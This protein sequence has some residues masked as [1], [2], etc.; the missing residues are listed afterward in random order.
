MIPGVSG[1][2]P[3]W[4]RNWFVRHRHPVSR[5]LHYV[6]IPLTV[7]AV[8]LAGYQFWLW[9]WD[10]WWRPG[11]LLIAGYL[12]QWIGHRLE[13]NDMGEVV[14]VKKLLGRSY[15]AISPRYTQEGDADE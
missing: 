3:R 12:P 10:L 15:Q 5:G 4:L 2:G 9:R 7:A 14:L 6:G 11:L 13:G 1:S 8:L